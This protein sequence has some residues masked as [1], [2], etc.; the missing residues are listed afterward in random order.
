M[1]PAVT[2]MDHSLMIPPSA[3]VPPMLWLCFSDTDS[4]SI[5]RYVAAKWVVNASIFGVRAVS[6]APIA[7]SDLAASPVWPDT[8][9]DVELEE[10]R[11]RD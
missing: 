10:F 2:K 9:P 8:N 5:N 4:A 3:L 7:W 6:E 1:V 11:C